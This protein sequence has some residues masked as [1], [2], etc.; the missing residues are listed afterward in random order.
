MSKPQDIPVTTAQIAQMAGVRPSAVS[1]WRRR[2]EDFPASIGSGPRGGDLFS[3]EAVT[4]WLRAHGH[5]VAEAG[6]G[7]R[8]F[9]LLD[10]LRGVMATDEAVG[11][12]LRW[13]IVADAVE[14]KR[15]RQ[16]S[17][18]ALHQDTAAVLAELRDVSRG[19]AGHDDA[20]W[21]FVEQKPEVAERVLAECLRLSAQDRCAVLEYLLARDTNVARSGRRT[22]ADLAQLLVDLAGPIEG[23]VL[24]PATGAGDVLLAAAQSARGGQTV[25]LA[26]ESISAPDAAF[27]SARLAMHGLTSDIRAENSLSQPTFEMATADIVICD[28]PLGH[29]SA[30]KHLRPDDPR[31]FAGT[32]SASSADFAWIQ[33]A[34][35]LT[36]PETGRA[37]V[38]TGID[39][40]FAGGRAD[41]IRRVLLSKGMVEAVIAL[42]AG[43][44][45]RH[46]SIGLAVWVLRRPGANDPMRNVTFVDAT[47][48]GRGSRRPLDH[49]LREKIVE[50]VVAGRAVTTLYDSGPGWP[51]SLRQDQMAVVIAG[52]EQAL[53]PDEGFDPRA[54]VGEALDDVLSSE[55]WDA[56]RAVY[57]AFPDALADISAKWNL[58]LDFS[59]YPRYQVEIPAPHRLEDLLR[60]GS[61]EMLAG[62]RVPAEA[63]CD[64]G[65][66][67]VRGHRSAVDQRHVDPALLP[68][69]VVLT[70]SGDLIVQPRPMGRPPLV[71]LS[72]AEG[73]ALIYPSI[74]LR[75]RE[76]WVEPTLLAAAVETAAASPRAA[77]IGGTP[78]SMRRWLLA[79]EI[80]RLGEEEANVAA[81]ALRSFDE[82][83]E[84]LRSAADLVSEWRAMN[85]R[86]IA[87]GRASVT[88]VPHEAASE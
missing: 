1:N 9:S 53:A 73:E 6:A 58:A 65:T 84:T 28:P 78:R 56:G 77:T 22:D 59:V 50:C 34:L 75:P 41:Q 2:H 20:L 63:Y 13:L 24:D 3:R 39:A 15:A 26:G 43:S 14:P 55:M 83:V 82:L 51:G 74:C 47:R 37:I 36:K 35:W 5:D 42:P 38:V 79:V 17:N 23:L 4:I 11:L 54:W 72:A 60:G 18:V 45:G 86:H 12:A 49:E 52:D 33:H 64:Q 16:L 29:R 48:E 10:S 44:A 81:Q 57:P 68:D 69:D 46:T 25:F 27:A 8:I 67:V 70:K 19:L 21:H 80:P 88:R 32:P 62:L 85:V 7:E 76:A 30:A 66:P 40:T 87:S 31:W 61:V 71:A